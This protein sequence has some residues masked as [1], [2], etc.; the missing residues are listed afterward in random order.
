MATLTDEQAR[1]WYA[2]V[3]A[4]ARRLTDR[5]PEDLV[6]TAFLR[7]CQGGHPGATTLGGLCHFVGQAHIDRW[8][9]ETWRG[10]VATERLEPWT[11]GAATAG[12][13]RA[14][15]DA[16]TLAALAALPHGGVLLAHGQGYTYTEIAARTGLPR[17]T[18][19]TRIMRLRHG[20]LAR[21]SPWGQ[22]T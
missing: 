6:Q 3:L 10:R 11:P 16:E 13:E 19:A 15:C 9:T 14:V 8:R 4:H 18:V 22:G 7:V 21:L 5:D 20:P 12:P 2:P 17:G 1:D